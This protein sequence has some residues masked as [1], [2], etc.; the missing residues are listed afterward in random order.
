VPPDDFD[1]KH[2]T[3]ELLARLP[4]YNL[5]FAVQQY[6]LGSIASDRERGAEY[7]ILWLA[8]F[9]RHPRS[10]DPLATGALLFGLTGQL[11]GNR[12]EPS[13]RRT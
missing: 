6:A 2:L 5:P 8:R 10:G 1:A 11:P 13:F 9:D 12:L 4:D 7:A 3:P